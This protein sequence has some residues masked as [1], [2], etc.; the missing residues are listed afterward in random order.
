M[1]LSLVQFAALRRSRWTVRGTIHRGRRL[2]YIDEFGI[3]RQSD[4]Y[5]RHVID[6][7]RL[8]FPLSN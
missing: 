3:L 5:R 8:V 1:L 4:A 2:I 6:A 7:Q